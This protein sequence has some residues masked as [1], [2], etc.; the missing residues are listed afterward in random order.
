M[1][2][3]D[4]DL[5]M[6]VLAK[7]HEAQRIL[8]ATIVKNDGCAIEGD[9]EFLDRRLDTIDFGK[10][11]NTRAQNIFKNYQEYIGGGQHKRLPIVTVRDLVRT[12]SLSEFLREPNAGPKT[13]KAVEDVLAEH[14]LKL[15]NGYDE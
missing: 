3:L 4:Q 2:A 8:E 12:L 13:I 14:G 11:H 15:R 1:N 6:R 5:I 7:L 9:P 10:C